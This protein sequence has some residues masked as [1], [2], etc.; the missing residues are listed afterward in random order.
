[1]RT[2]TLTLAAAATLAFSN[3]TSASVVLDWSPVATGGSV[4]ADN[5]SN[6]RPG[7]YFAESVQ[8]SSAQAINGIDIYDSKNVGRLGD[9][10]VVSIWANAAGSPGTLAAQ[11]F[12]NIT[13]VD[14]VGASAKEH[15]LH[16][17]FSSF[18]MEA[19]TT[20]WIG[21]AGDNIELAQT[22]LEG[23][24]GGDG[25]MWMFSSDTD[26]KVTLSDTGDMAFRL[27]GTAANNVPEPSSLT[28][29]GLGLA[30]LTASRRR[31][32]A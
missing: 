6:Q 32:A 4:V 21:M 22:S 5:R 18:T 30:G 23:V 16:A 12:T 15:R 17:D 3:I 11:F 26:G 1:M 8:F 7:Q 24:A 10:V 2:I 14:L 19:A 20:Y 29:L 9:A 25:L 27:E 28:L 31:K 13:A